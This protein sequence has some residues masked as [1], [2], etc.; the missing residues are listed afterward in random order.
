A[1]GVASVSCSRMGGG[2]GSADPKTDDE[3]VFYALGLDI[4]KNIDV[5]G[6]QPNEAELVKAG[7]GDAIAKRKPKVD[8][9]AV[10]PKIFEM[11]RKRQEAKAGQEKAKGKAA[12]DKAA[13]ESGAQQLP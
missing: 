5:F 10:R 1:C 12:V 11:A 8:L 7:L 2:S 13:K 4:G 6:L 3:K 9:D